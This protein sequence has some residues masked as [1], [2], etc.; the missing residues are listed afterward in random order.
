MTD[1]AARF[2]ENLVVLRGRAGL[3][4][5]KTAERSGL[6]ITEVSLLERGLRLP[7]LDTIVKLA[8][9]LGVEPC[10]LLVGM[11]WCLGQSE[12]LPGAYVSHG[13]FVERSEPA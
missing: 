3:S 11:K 5:G 10:V 7:R 2:A 6:H 12:Q 8:G 4:Q 1:I 9:G 13:E